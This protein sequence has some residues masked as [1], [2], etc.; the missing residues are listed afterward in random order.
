MALTAQQILDIRADLGIGAS[1]AADEI[2][3]DTELNV[4]FDRAGSDY[5]TAVYFGWRQILANSVKYIDYRVAQTSISRSQAFDH[6]LR[7]VAFW[8]AESKSA[9]D[10]LLSAG[11]NQV[12]TSHKRKPMDEYHHDG[13]FKRGRWYPYGS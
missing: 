13:Y 4:L 2:F 5:N 3:S 10:Q 6:I 1:G 11:L 9:D 8:A 7:M 12:P